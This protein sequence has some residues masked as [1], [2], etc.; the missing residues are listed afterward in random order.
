MKARAAAYLRFSSLLTL[1][2]LLASAQSGRAPQQAAQ[3]APE[4]P[5]AAIEKARAF[6][7][8][9]IV[10][11]VPG[12]SVAV[13]QDGK[14]L[15]SEGFGFADLEGQRP[16][17]TESRF[18]IGSVSKPVTAAGLMLLVEQGRLDLDAD[19]RKYLPD[20]PD[21][22]HVIT[23]R[24]LAGHLA[25]IRH[26]RGDEFLLNRPFATV[27]AGLRIFEDDPL[28]SPP[29]EK[30]SYSSYGWNL[31]SA[32]M[33]SSARQDFLAYMEQ[34]VFRPLRLTTMGPDFASRDVPGRVSFYQRGRDGIGFARGPEVDNSYK[35]AGGGFL[36]NMEDLV[37]FGSALLK[38]GFLKQA[39]LDQLFTS[40]KTSDGKET[41]YGIGWSVTKD[42]EGHEIRLHTG[43]SVGGTTVLILHPESRI[44]MAMAANVSNGPLRKE[45][46]EKIVE[47]FASFFASKTKAAK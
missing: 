2:V 31:I 38:P 40:Q 26:Y 23:T 46:R 28:L 27:R 37:R 10:P 16:V 5:A 39:S 20:F 15:W 43:G 34:R 44:V 47:M 42:A 11:R 9:N 30:F 3:R 41:G 45:D 7:R 1:F 13:A 21:K 19:I 4:S 17:T 29:G 33:E 25:G 35:W 32:V 18:R 22:G 8:E 36:S 6:L 12:L 24:L 14:I